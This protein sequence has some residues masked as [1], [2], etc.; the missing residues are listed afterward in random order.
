MRYLPHTETELRA[1][2]EA[3]GAADVDDLFRAVPAECRLRGDLDL[4]PALDEAAL[5]RHLKQLASRNQSNEYSFMGAGMTQHHV[6]PA[7]DQLLLR[8]EFYTAYTPYQAEVSQG[9]L[10]TMFEFQ[11]IVSEL[12]GLP[13]ANA[14]MYDGASALA[15]AALM[16]LR[17]KAGSRKIAVSAG[18]HPHYTDVLST[19]LRGQDPPID[20]VELP[21][22]SDGRT[23]WELPHSSD[24]AVGFAAVVAPYPNVYGIVEDLRQA[25]ELARACEALLVSVTTEPYALGVVESPGALGA[26]IAVAEGQPLATTPSY[27]GPGVGLFA[28]RTGYLRQ[29]PGRVVGETVD[30]DGKRCFA[31]TLSTREQHIRRERATSNICTNHG[32]VA[33]A[34][35]MR[36]ALLGKQGFKDA[37]ML[38]LRNAE[39]LKKRLRELPGIEIPFD[40]PTFN[41]FVVACPGKS[42]ARLLDEMHRRTAFA[43]GVPLG[44]LFPGRD[45][46][47]FVATTELHD[48]EALDRYVEALDSALNQRD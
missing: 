39:Y 31:L 14:S 37:A 2:L 44:S 22:R 35:T 48:K 7:V 42:A 4:P 11:T 6:P 34:L 28:T 9:T 36:A 41:E 1:M 33:L 26:D 32:L 3:V 19:Y 30:G 47:W 40:A 20:I 23:S 21:L 16:A 43:A 13:V 5:M 45:D 25:D 18:M 12:L 15:E 29:M 46:G 38:C 17:I 8:G 27:G 10:Q 24:G